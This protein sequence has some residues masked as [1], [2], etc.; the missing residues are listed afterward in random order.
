M[1][2]VDFNL[3]YISHLHLKL[4]YR[5]INCRLA[6]CHVLFLSFLFIFQ[7]K[8]NIFTINLQYFIR[9]LRIEE[10]NRLFK[11]VDTVRAEMVEKNQRH[12]NSFSQLKIASE[13]NAKR[14][15][16]V[17]LLAIFLFCIRSSETTMVMGKGN[18][19]GTGAVPTNQES[20][21]W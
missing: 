21:Q 10:A 12:W 17:H 4:I 15:S 11:F 14:S 13:S 6:E 5:D 2:L 3:I 16:C 20:L 9:V 8:R 19:S 1:L 7:W 18:N